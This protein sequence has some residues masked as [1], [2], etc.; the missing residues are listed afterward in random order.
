MAHLAL[1][2]GQDAVAVAAAD[3]AQRPRGDVDERH[4]EV[5]AR[6]AEAAGV[7]QVNVLVPGGPAVAGERGLATGGGVVKCGSPLVRDQRCIRLYM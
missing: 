7:Q 2:V 4:P 1:L 6:R 3:R 5:D